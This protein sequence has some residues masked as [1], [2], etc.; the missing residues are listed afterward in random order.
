MPRIFDN[1]EKYLTTALQES[2][3]LS[4]R[5]D[6]CVGYFNLRGW[7]EI[8]EQIENFHGGEGRQ[9]RLLVGMPVSPDQELKEL[10]S[11]M[12]TKRIDQAESIQLKRKLAESFRLQLCYGV[13]TNADEA[14][15]RRL[16]RQLKA[17]KVR[18][19]LHTRHSLHAKL[20]LAYREDPTNP[21]MGYM[22]SSNL[23]FAGLARQG[24]LNIDVLD[25]DAAKKLSEWFEA[26]WQD[27]FCIDI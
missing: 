4:F 1:I 27:R 23:T 14:G 17:G 24:E 19:K 16:L 9:C 7:K 6:F 15:L 2:L 18:V 8:D 25:P 22:G 21:I 10:F 11:T 13:P 12:T 5:A 3:H 26:R 20:Y